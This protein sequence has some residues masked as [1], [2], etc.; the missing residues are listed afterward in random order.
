MEQTETFVMRRP[1]TPKK[2][3]SEAP[4]IKREPKKNVY[5]KKNM[6]DVDVFYGRNCEGTIVPIKEIQDEIG[7]VVIDG[8]I[9]NVESREIKG[10]KQ[11]VTFAITDY[12]DTIVCKVFIKN[13]QITETNFFDMVKKGNFIRVKGVASLDS[14][15]KEIRIGSIMGMKEIEG[16]RVGREDH[17]PVKRVELHAHTQMSD[18]DGIT[19]VDQLVR[20]AHEWGHPAVAITDH[21]VVQAFPDA[22]HALEGLKLPEDDPFKVIYGCEAYLVD[23]LND[24]AVDNEKG[25]SLRDEYVV[26]DLETTGFSSEHDKIIEIGAVRVKNGKISEKYSTFVNPERKIPERITELTSI[27]DDMVKD[28][29]VI[30]KVLPDFLKFIGDNA[31]VAHNA[32]FDH[33]FIRQKAKDQG[34]ETDFTVVDT[35]GLARVL[36]PELAKYKL[37]NIAKKLKISLENHH[38]AVDDAGATAEIF[39]KF[40]EMLEEKGLHTLK[41]VADFAN[42]SA[43]IVKK[44]PYFHAII[45]A[46]NETGRINL[47]RLVSMG[48]LDYFYRKPRVPKSMFLKYRDGLII[49]SACEAGELYRALLDEAPESR[50]K[51]LV[52]F[53]DYLEIQP[54]GNNKFMIE[55]ERVENIHSFEDLKDMNRKIVALG[56]KY[57]KP[58]CATCDVHFLDPEDEIY[59]KIIFAGKKMKDADDQPPL[60]LRTTEEML[61]EFSYLGQEKAFEVVVTN[62]NLIAD[63]IEKMSPVYPDKCPPV[64]PKSDE[65]LTNICYNKAISMYGDPLPPQVKNRLDHEL[66]SIIKNGFAVMYIIAQKLVWKSNEDGYLVGSRGS[67]GSSFVAT[68][69]GITEVNPLPAHYYCKKCHY[70]DFDSE[71]VK[72]YAGS[73]GCDMPPKKCPNCGEQLIQ[74]GHDI[75]FETFL[76][77]YGD[78]EPDIDLNFSGEYQSKAHAYTEVIFGAGQTFRAGTIATLADKTAY[79]YVKNYFEERGQHKRNEEIERIIEGCV[80]IRRSTGQHPGGIIVL[81]FGW[82]IYTF[83]PVQHPAN[84]QNTPIITTHFDYHSIDHNLLKLDILGHDDPTMIRMLED[85]TGIDAKTISLDNQEVLSLFA[86]TSALG[87]TP[88]DLMGCDLGSLGIPEFGTDFVMQML[89]DTKPKNFSDLVRISGLSHGTDVWL[90][91]AQ[92]FIKEGNCTLS[93][94]I[95]TRDDIMTYLIH[96]GVENGLAF[97]IM[98][99]VRKG[100]GL[101]EDMEK[102]MR[103]AGVEDWYI[104]SC[105][106]IKYMFPKAHAVAYVMMAFRIAYFKVFYPLAY[107]AAFFSIRA[108]AFDYQLMCQGREKLESTMRDYKKRYNELSKKEQDSYNDM[109]IVQEMYARGFEFMPIDIFRA[110]ANHFQVVDGKLMPALSTIDGMGGKAAEGVVEAAKHG[111]FSSRENF[112]LRAKISGTVVE[113]MAEMGILGDLPETDQMSLLDFMA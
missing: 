103:E 18:M 26:F 92:Y 57:N 85:L 54:I 25:Q 107:Y 75:P 49:G 16:F 112:K 89:R 64:I 23:D 105:K 15:D 91:N 27:T 96:T 5:R 50:I 65:T 73:S 3:E 9:R 10:E 99:S 30:E 74:E 37:D 41:E 22:N 51:E 104:E 60:F 100:K 19:H 6:R 47:Y 44:K 48:H 11:I 83:T 97:K 79:G 38:R 111:P 102:A 40:V 63:R 93:T 87:V 32:G 109:K 72:K 66:D 77:F 82:E 31:L 12:T 84:D 110:K 62:T 68:M 61:E 33:G 71:E 53:Y 56:E 46:A 14:Y 78:K 69:S 101:T 52:D 7:E 1:E 108:K 2:E 45:L 88:E 13:E 98:E 42:G 95:C 4:R 59:R 21:G 76:G 39:E 81:P 90:N 43:D 36:F 28:A 80:G 8:M 70:V 55:S 35:V 58:V 113:K 86:N 106:R 67:V 34:I 24:L 20:R 17:A 94:A 29:P